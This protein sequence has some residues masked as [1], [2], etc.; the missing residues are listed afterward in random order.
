MFFLFRL[1]ES[2]HELERD[3]FER[4]LQQEKSESVKGYIIIFI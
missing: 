1:L 2:Q 3:R 4:E